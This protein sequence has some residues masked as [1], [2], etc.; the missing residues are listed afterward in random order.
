L[1][2]VIQSRP[3]PGSSNSSSAR[4]ACVRTV[5]SGR[6]TL[7]SDAARMVGAFD[8]PRFGIDS[9]LTARCTVHLLV[10]D[11]ALDDGKQASPT[12]ETNCQSSSREATTNQRTHH[13]TI[14]K[15]CRCLDHTMGAELG[16]HRSEM[17]TWS[18]KTSASSLHKKTMLRFY[19]HSIEK[20]L[21]SSGI[22][23]KES[24]RFPPRG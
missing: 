18:G 10:L 2:M 7:S 22:I 8:L 19:P 23:L 13:A 3:P 11:I 15:I 5:E 24:A 16:R 1:R 21:A 4:R 17:W 12:V 9:D 20:Y 14:W 6:R